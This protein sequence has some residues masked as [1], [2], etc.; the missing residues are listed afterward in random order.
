MKRRQHT[1]TMFLT[2][3]S[4]VVLAIMVSLTVTQATQ[5]GEAEQLAGTWQVE[6]TQRNCQ[7]GAAIRTYPALFTYVP[8][9]S[10]LGTSTDTSPALRTPAHGI[11]QHTGGRNFTATWIFFRFNP[12]GTYAGTVQGTTNIEVGEGDNE[13]TA[14]SSAEIRDVSGNLITTGCTTQTAR[15]LE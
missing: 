9:G 1:K 7:T 6:V 13:F 15:R 4:G 2:A 3:I 5:G 12:D 14:T 8:G 10:L 11:W